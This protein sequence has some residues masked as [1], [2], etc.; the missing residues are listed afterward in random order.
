MKLEKHLSQ[1]K[2]LYLTKHGD[3]ISVSENIHFRW[4][5]FNDVV[6]SIMHKR[7][8]SSLT[9]P[10]QI[11][12]LL[13]LL[14]FRPKNIVELGLGGGNLTR[15]LTNLSTEINIKSI[16]YNKDVIECFT[17]FFNPDHE[18]M[19]IILADGINW[20]EQQDE[21]N[22]DWLICDVY[23]SDEF[24]FSSIVKQFETLTSKLDSQSCLSINLPDVSD[25]EINL[26]LT[27]LQQLQSKHHIQYFHIPN[28]LNIVIHLYPKNWP[29]HRLL[30]LRAKRNKNSY[31]SPLKFNRWRKFWPHGIHI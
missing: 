12:L 28:Y 10:H 6:Q 13:P 11:A 29:V 19:D 1:G 3:A 26:C 20:L 5:A 22:I 8:P 4:I 31:L 9:L 27:I 30:K 16:E 2:L 23:R 17:E 7:K 14:L 18:N 25:E 24:G 15:F 21:K